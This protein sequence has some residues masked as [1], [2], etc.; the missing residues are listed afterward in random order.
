MSKSISLETGKSFENVVTAEIV[1]FEYNH[2]SERTSS[3]E[4]L[5]MVLYS[6]ADVCLQLMTE[7]FDLISR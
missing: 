4:R 3:H 1:H 5:N 7:S 6:Y 2:L